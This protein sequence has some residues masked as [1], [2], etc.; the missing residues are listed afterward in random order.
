[1]GN[2]L[3]GVLI[4]NSTG[5]THL[6]GFVVAN[7]F[8]VLHDL[9]VA[10]HAERALAAQAQD[11]PAGHGEAPAIAPGREAALQLGLNFSF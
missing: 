5:T 7:V 6:K 11:L 10:Q 1:M 2:S 9:S 8:G 3:G 4:K